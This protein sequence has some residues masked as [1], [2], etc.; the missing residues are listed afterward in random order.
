V[1]TDSDRAG[2]MFTSDPGINPR[3][4]LNSLPHRMFF[5]YE[6]KIFAETNDDG[7]DYHFFAS[8]DAFTVID[9]EIYMYCLSEDTMF[10]C[11]KTLDCGGFAD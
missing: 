1:N 7:Y 6:H 8:L 11:L 10:I 9:K 5:H 3:R 4:G 2:V